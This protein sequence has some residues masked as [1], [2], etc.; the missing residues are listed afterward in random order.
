M[1]LANIFEAI[2]ETIENEIFDLILQSGD[3][4]IERIISKGHASPASGWYQQAQ[5]EWVI[6]MQGAAILGFDDDQEI[7]LEAG[8]HYNIPA[9]TRHKVLWTSDTPATVWLAVHYSSDK[10]GVS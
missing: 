5:H 8:D 7:R 1:S 9:Q 4:K 2:P 3:L 6:V 10:N